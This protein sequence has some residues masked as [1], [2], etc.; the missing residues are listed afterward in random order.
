M[1]E[2]TFILEDFSEKVI[3]IDCSHFRDDEF[4]E[5]LQAVIDSEYSDIDYREYTYKPAN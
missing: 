3:S 5:D 2:V 4:D 1:V